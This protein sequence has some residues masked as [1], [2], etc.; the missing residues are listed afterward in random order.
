MDKSANIKTPSLKHIAII[1]DGNRRWARKQ[2]LAAWL[3]HQ[4]GSETLE[5]LLEVLV[6]FEVPHFSFWGSS[7]DNLR[8]RP[9]EEVDFLLKIFKQQF[10]RL[11][12]D[13]KIHD[14]QIRISVIGSWEEQFPPE[15]K[16]PMY[17]AIE[18]TKDY[19]RYN[20]NFF[21]AYSGMDEMLKAAEKLAA[22]KAADPALEV[23]P[24]LLKRQLLTRDL[25]A[26]DLLIRTGGEPHNSDGFMMWD[27]ANSQ[28]VF[29]EKLWPEFT[30]KDL[31]AAI[32]DYY[33]RE[34]RLGK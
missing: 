7:Q 29:S 6:R 4:K 10:A 28:F 32:E 30:E 23:T 12:T 14:N 1:P 21:L 18:R 8:K 19:E 13:R 3:G 9:K 2:S 33:G 26:V 31:E 5:D 34:R 11:C 25:P 22:L 15:V 27:T 24:Q 16:K 17:E 20:L